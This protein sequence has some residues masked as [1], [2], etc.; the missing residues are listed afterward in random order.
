MK[1]K[2]GRPKAAVTTSG[3]NDRKSNI[4]ITS[5]LIIRNSHRTLAETP[6]AKISISFLYDYDSKQ[7][8]KGLALKNSIEQFKLDEIEVYINV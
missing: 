8:I 2:K 5:R 4:I 3:L 1:R 7:I 6:N